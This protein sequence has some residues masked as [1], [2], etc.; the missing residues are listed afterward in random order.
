LNALEERCLFL[1]NTYERLQAGRQK[2]QE[3]VISYLDDGQLLFS[4]ER[5]SKQQETLGEIGRSI[6]NCV[7]KL[8]EAENRKLLLRQKLLE[9]LAAAVSP[10]MARQPPQSHSMVFEF[11]KPTRR[12]TRRSHPKLI[13]PTKPLQVNRKGLESITIYADNQSYE[14]I[15]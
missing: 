7:A 10:T 2:L 6:D 13:E 9:H 3:R 5:L 15:R 11:P 14:P 4:R 8:V 12:A 1:H